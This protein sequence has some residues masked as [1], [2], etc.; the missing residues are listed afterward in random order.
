MNLDAQKNV[1]Q[2]L[3]T[4]NTT[5]TASLLRRTL[6]E[7]DVLTSYAC[8]NHRA[9]FFISN[10]VHGSDNYAIILYISSDP[11]CNHIQKF[12]VQARIFFK[13][14]EIQSHFFY[15]GTYFHVLQKFVK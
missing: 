7:V 9:F 5:F 6:Y 12:F 13:S 11:C 10:G 2:L 3:P 4:I 8:L 14:K 1:A 15:L